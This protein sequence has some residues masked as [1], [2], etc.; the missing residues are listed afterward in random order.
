MEQLTELPIIDCT[1]INIT[2]DDAEIDDN[3]L[4]EFGEDIFESFKRYDVTSAVLTNHGISE[5]VV[6]A[7]ERVTSELEKPDFKKIAPYFAPMKLGEEFQRKC[8][9][10]I[11]GEDGGIVK[12]S[13]A[14]K[15]GVQLLTKKLMLLKKD[16]SG[17]TFNPEN[18]RTLRFVPSLA[19]V[20]VLNID[21]I[22]PGFNKAYNA[23]FCESL[24]LAKRVLTALTFPLHTDRDYFNKMIE[25][26]HTPGENGSALR[27]NILPKVPQDFPIDDQVVR[28]N[29]HEDRSIITILHQANV[30][31]LTVKT[32]SGKSVPVVHKGDSL[33]LQTGNILARLTSGKLPPT[34]HS[35]MGNKEQLQQ[36]RIS[37]AF[38]IFPDEK[39]ELRCID[40]SD[41]Y[42]PVS[43]FIL[44]NDLE[45]Q[46]L[47]GVKR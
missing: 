41:T 44:L 4:R 29:E 1:K 20:S 14:T 43:A 18:G 46:D 32:M 36:S 6:K 24:K 31:G 12:H 17:D 5:E 9:I 27:G 15:H 35:V 10:H 16:K 40:G 22:I 3:D 11:D 34:P 8:D 47:H 39:V 30:N 37:H 21:D 26:I 7:A 38:L 45:N 2:L 25:D 33:L 28:I 23:L 42:P 13:F 19:Q